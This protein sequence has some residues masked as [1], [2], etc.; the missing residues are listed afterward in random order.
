MN[1]EISFIFDV[2]GAQLKNETLPKVPQNLD[3]DKVYKIAKAHN[4]LN[5]IA[6]G[7]KKGDYNPDEEL[8]KKFLQSLYTSL[9]VDENQKRDFSVLFDAFSKND[10]KFL[11]LKGI[12]L[13][14]IYPSPDMRNMSDGDILID[15]AD[16]DKIE[17]LMESLGYTFIKESN[18]ELIYQK[19][20]FTNVELHK[21]LVP[22]YNEDLYAY[23]GD[24]WDRA[25]KRETSQRYEMSTEDTFIYIITH[26]AKHY[27][28]G[29]A[30]IKYIIDIWLYKN[31]YDIDMDYVL[32]EM[33][34]MNLE[35]FTLCLLKL[36]R[37]WFEGEATDDLTLSMTQYII[38]SGQ[39]GSMKNAT[40]VGTM[41]ENQEK[42]GK[43]VAKRGLLYLLFPN[44]SH[45][46]RNYP[47]LRKAPYLIPFL[48][49]WR[50]IR[51][52][53]GK[54][55]RKNIKRAS[56]LSKQNVAEFDAHMKALGLDIYNGRKQS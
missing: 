15:I 47:V 39:Y 48:W 50:W 1:Q 24:G 43:E 31:S 7:I 37:V 33:K 9:I 52:V 22:S 25:K 5:I 3:W 16:R 10:I 28:D 56:Y 13:K 38:G 51:I 11:P 34:K 46:K 2:I 6:Y 54:T 32:T 30:G 21:I 55:D 42:S 26:F 17:K 23:Y 49:I 53:V 4:I 45:M 29:G 40:L 41:R 19:P 27:R 12:V 14:P 18:H 44:F 8:F 36:T 20:P 35:K